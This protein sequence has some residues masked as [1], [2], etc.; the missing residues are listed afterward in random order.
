MNKKRVYNLTRT[1]AIIT[2]ASSGIGES[3]AKE[4]ASEGYDLI[5]TARREEILEELAKNLK[6]T[7]QIDVEV[8]VA[9]LSNIDEIESLSEKIEKLDDIDILVNNA[10][11]GLPGSFIESDKS[12]QLDMLY[13]HNIASFALSRA[14]L[15]SMIER[16][17][18]AIINVSSVS[19]LMSRF[20]N[21]TYTVTKA[22][23]VVLSEA[24]QEELNGTNIRIQALCPGMTKSGFHDTKELA[25]FDKTS[26]PKNFWMTSDEVV[27]KS[28]KALQRKKAIY[29]PGFRNRLIVKTSNNFLTGRIIRYYASKRL[30]REKQTEK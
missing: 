21:V 3:F 26:V 11:F 10:G 27:K 17:K 24:L 1:K 28:L 29:V 2:G 4:L 22:F 8:V 19:G 16:D 5:I 6:K 20:G 12:L 15:P 13:V 25:S 14:V 7:Y 9:D 23:L 30:K 18:G